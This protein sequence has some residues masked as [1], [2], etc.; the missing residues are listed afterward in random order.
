MVV[1]NNWFG[2]GATPGAGLSLDCPGATD[3]GGN[4]YHAPDVEPPDPRRP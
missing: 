2:D 4:T 1:S 3:G